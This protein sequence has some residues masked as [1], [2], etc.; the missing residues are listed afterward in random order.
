MSLF[1]LIFPFSDTAR[2]NSKIKI[3]DAIAK[4]RVKGKKV[5]ATA[6]KMQQLMELLGKN[7]L[8]R[9]LLKMGKSQKV[10]SLSVLDRNCN[11]S[12]QMFDSDTLLPLA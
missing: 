1:S 12:S 9:G 2:L 7:L 6:K 10:L 8:I 11:F 4:I 5:V 3:I